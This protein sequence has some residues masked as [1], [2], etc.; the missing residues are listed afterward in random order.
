MSNMTARHGNRRKID[1]FQPH[2]G[3][4]G[5]P[6]ESNLEGINNGTWRKSL[7]YLETSSYETLNISVDHTYAKYSKPHPVT[8]STD[9]FMLADEFHKYNMKNPAD[10]LRHVSL[11]PE[12]CGKIN[13][14]V[15]E[16]LFKKMN[17]CA[18][19]LN[20]MTPIHHSLML[21]LLLH[22][23]NQELNKTMEDNLTNSV[24]GGIL[25]T[26]NFG[27][28]CVTLRNETVIPIPSKNSAPV[29]KKT[30]KAGLPTEQQTTR[31]E[32]DGEKV[33]EH[34]EPHPGIV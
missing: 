22:L 14:Q 15:V 32:F 26:D 25:V 20:L 23:H 27:R 29:G 9:H 19:F 5:E 2:L 16:Q 13:T 33:N 6:S 11:V 3:R 12:L 28:K 1:M 4:L 17:K 10:K 31:K 7:S 30:N 21:R 8:G 18:N 24:R 34:L